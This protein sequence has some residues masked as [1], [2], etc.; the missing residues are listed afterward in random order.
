M[1]GEPEPDEELTPAQRAAAQ[2]LGLLRLDPP[3]P[4][5][6]LIRRVMRTTRWQHAVKAPL[7]VVIMIAEP[8]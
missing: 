1:S 7:R 6:A 8:C 2:H 4:D 3:T 5:R